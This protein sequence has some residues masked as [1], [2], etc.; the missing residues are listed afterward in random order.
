[1]TG[2]PVWLWWTLGAFIL[3][4]LLKRDQPRLWLLF[5]LVA[6]LGLTTKLTILFFGVALTLALLVTPQRRYLRTPWPWLGG[7]VM[8]LIA[9][10]IALLS[11]DGQVGV[12]L[13]GDADRAR[14][15]PALGKA[16]QASLEELL[17]S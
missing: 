13:L 14:D 12:G 16:L 5:G 15:L 6:G 2:E 3:I 11:Y 4:R 1:M 9:L 8:V 17:H 10:G 7:A